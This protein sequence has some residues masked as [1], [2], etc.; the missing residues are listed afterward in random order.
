MEG[1]NED[2]TVETMSRPRGNLSEFYYIPNTIG[3]HLI[4]LSYCNVTIASRQVEAHYP[5]FALSDFSFSLFIDCD[6]LIRIPSRIELKV[7]VISQF[8]ETILHQA[9]MRWLMDQMWKGEMRVEEESHSGSRPALLLCNASEDGFVIPLTVEE[10]GEVTVFLYFGEKEIGKLSLI[11]QAAPPPI[12]DPSPPPQSTSS[13]ICPVARSPSPILE[14][15][16]SVD[17]PPPITEAQIYVTLGSGDSFLEYLGLTNT[18]KQLTIEQTTTCRDLF[19]LM[20]TQM[21]K[22]SDAYHQKMLEDHCKTYRFF[23]EEEGGKRTPIKMSDKL[24]DHRDARIVFSPMVEKVY[25]SV[26]YPMTEFLVNEKI[27]IIIEA[28]DE[29]G[30][31]IADH[32]VGFLGQLLNFLFF[33]FFL[34][35]IYLH[36]LMFRFDFFV[37]FLFY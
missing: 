30:G 11:G 21:T 9:S 24:W 17:V 29:Q 20:V 31:H 25:F 7:K 37:L 27:S 23:I 5:P 14:V 19:H 15:K 4:E 1:P 8:Q 34:Y 18:E 22:I 6:R 33:S 28:K 32:C 16:P 12:R 10:E 2:E 36:P 3:L 35:S 26:E 13:Q